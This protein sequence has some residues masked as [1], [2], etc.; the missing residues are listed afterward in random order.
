MGPVFYLVQ[1][2]EELL[3]I[4]AVLLIGNLLP[5]LSVAEGQRGRGQRLVAIAITR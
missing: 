2:E 5:G 4:S 3:L 1:C